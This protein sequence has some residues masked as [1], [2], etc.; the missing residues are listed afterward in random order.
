[1][2]F[3]YS[4]LTC[5]QGISAAVQSQSPEGL[6]RAVAAVGHI[7]RYTPSTAH[8]SSHTPQTTSGLH[9]HSHS[10]LVQ[11]SGLLRTVAEAL[12]ATAAA[13]PTSAAVHLQA[14]SHSWPVESLVATATTFVSLTS[15]PA[16]RIAALGFPCIVGLVDSI[17][18][19]LDVAIEQINPSTTPF[20]I[21]KSVS[22]TRNT[23]TA[24]SSV[25]QHAA[26]IA[27]MAVLIQVLQC[28]PV[29]QDM[30]C[31]RCDVIA[32]AL[33][34][35][36]VYRIAHFFLLMHGTVGVAT[37]V[38][39]S[40]RHSMQLLELLTAADP[41]AVLSTARHFRGS[42]DGL[43]CLRVKVSSTSSCILEKAEH[44]HSNASH[45]LARECR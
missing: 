1:M 7:D 2:R 16:A 36:I 3:D 12:V 42:G 35:G 41:R 44:R 37:T 34:A 11:I 29:S 31:R 9:A 30:R 39:A 18:I 45:Q 10:D 21:D 38:P 8:P 23:S 24:P 15:C 43:V 4:W 32:Y 28:H 20:D 22:P 40:V 27:C 5:L 13:S 33:A 19:H 6:M 26:V 17:R 14:T 25:P